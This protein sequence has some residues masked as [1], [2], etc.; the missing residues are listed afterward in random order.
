M[1][2]QEQGTATGPKRTGFSRRHETS[3]ANDAARQKYQSKP[4]Q[5]A[6]QRRYVRLRARAALEPLL[7]K[8]QL[9][10]TR[11]AT[12]SDKR[13]GMELEKQRKELRAAMKPYEDIIAANR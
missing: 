13:A 10:D 1:S 11:L 12:N 3:E 7:A 4:R 8:L 6:K 9:I 5:V 2:N